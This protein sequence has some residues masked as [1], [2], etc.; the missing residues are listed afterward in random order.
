MISWAWTLLLLNL[1]YLQKEME[2]EE[3]GGSGVQ[4]RQLSAE[5]VDKY[6]FLASRALMMHDILAR[7][8]R[9]PFMKWTM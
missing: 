2:R 3:A 6:I 8:Q 7:S 5:D 4:I 9:L 1:E